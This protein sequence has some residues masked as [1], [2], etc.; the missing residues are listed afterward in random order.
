M[1]FFSTRRISVGM[2]ME[3]KNIKI[4]LVNPPL[5]PGMARHPPNVPIGLAYLAA[6]AE[7]SGHTVKVIDCLPVDMDYDEMKREVAAFD[8]D[9]VGITS[10]TATSPSALQA[11]HVLKESCPAA[12]IVL[13]GPHATFTD[14]N[15][16]S[17]C[18]DVDV[19]VRKEGEET[20]L[21]LLGCVAKERKF[22]EVA[23]IT[24]R[25]NGKVV[26][27]P[28][29]PFIQN[30]DELPFP[31]LKHFPLS[32]YRIFGKSYLPII[33]SRGCPFQ[34]SFC[35]TSRMVGK[36]FRARSPKNVADELEWLR[37]V[38][39]AEA[40][41]FYDD[42]LTFDKKRTYEICDEIKKRKVDLPWDCTTRVDQVSRELLTKMREANCQEVFFGVESGCQ[43]ILDA[44]S[45][46]T[47]IELNEKAIRWAKEAGLFVA[48]SVIIGYPGETRNT[49]KQTLDFIRR[50]K[51]D[52]AY[53]CVAMP[54]PGT[55]LRALVEKLGWKMSSDWSRY[56]TMTPVFENPDLPSEEI[57]RIRR[58]FYDSFYS[59]RY[60]L[61]Q[62]EKGYLKGN[63]YSRIMARTALN[64]FLWR[65]R[66]HR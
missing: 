33:T 31:A 29:R 26:Q 66:I 46:R 38:H 24:F 58:I 51:P 23:G 65:I 47:S 50:L 57:T 4:A 59:P 30:L 14:I 8:P 10:M 63:F 34:C 42:M 36:T 55:E 6:V 16:L 53:L 56:D 15:T 39:R 11:A 28:D 41:V 21:E 9:I 19:V 32:K 35:V 44:V 12:L 27:T 48:L 5:L 18:A 20:L 22:D 62:T 7:K 52:D 43:Q 49:L 13:G 61:R 60:I 17:E 64:H 37:D 54:Y 45:K 25:K 40:F 3:R 2:F 1:K